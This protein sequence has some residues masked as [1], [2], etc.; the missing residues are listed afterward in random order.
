LNAPD[1]ERTAR[2]DDALR[3]ACRFDV[4][5][6]KPGNV[7]IESPGHDMH[8]VQFLRA[9]AVATPCLMNRDRSLGE[10][11]FD[12]VRASVRV[13]QCNT[14]LG[15]ILLA[16]PLVRAALLRNDNESLHDRVRSVL[17]NADVADAGAV[18]AAIRYAAPGG[19]G[20]SAEADVA[21]EP[22]L[23]LQEV[24][25]IA[26]VRDRIAFQYAHDFSDLFDFTVP[27]LRHY[28]DRWHSIAWASVGV[29]L[30]L[31]SR[32]NDTHIARKFG[33]DTAAAVRSSARALESDFKACENPA[34]L[35]AQLQ[36]F[37]CGLKRGGVNPGASADLTVASVLTLLLQHA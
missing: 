17:R 35:A 21:D 36:D 26:A 4:I 29:Y 9:A 3:R 37:D 14:N 27:L 32:Y 8:A 1:A 34:T 18:Y 31:L 30:A 16:A 33:S 10:I 19:L 12:A 5:A 2:I 11:I 20:R 28:R 24:M 7:S 25:R 13:T 22:E 23:R 15:I 6:F